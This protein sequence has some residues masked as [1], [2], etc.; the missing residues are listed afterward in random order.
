MAKTVM[1]P[2]T[3]FT[4]NGVDL[5]DHTTSVSIDNPTDAVE[6][7]GFAETYREFLPGL[8]DVTISADFIQDFASG[9]VDATLSALRDSATG[10]TVKVNPDTTGTVVYTL[11]PVKLYNYS[12]VSGGGPGDATTSTGVEFRNA[13]TVGL[14]RG[15]S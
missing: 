7:T 13:G 15:T 9:S 5:S 8:R 6:V 14:T 3:R 1:G 11:A 2:N 4:V 12:P 10:G